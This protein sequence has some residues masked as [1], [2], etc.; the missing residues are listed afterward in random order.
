MVSRRQVLAGLSAVAVSGF[1]PVSRTWVSTARAA[2]TLDHIP[3][4]DGTLLTDPASLAPYATDAG[5][6][7]HETPV[8]VLRP[9]S[10]EDV[11]KMIRYCRRHRIQVAA[12]GQGHTTFGQSQ[13]AGLVVDMGSLNKIHSIK[14]TS[15]DIDAG[16]TWRALVDTSVPMGLTPPVLTGYIKLSIGG[17]L[18]VGGVSSTN[19]QGCQVDRVQELEVVTGEGEI[20]RCSEHEN[21][22]LFE[23]VLGGLGQCGIVTRAVV[24]MV[25]APLNARTFI[26]NY[27]DNATFF[28]DM[29]EILRRNEVEDVFCLFLPDASGHLVYGLNITKFYGTGA[30]PDGAHLLRGLSQPASAATVTDQPYLNYV[31]R[32]DVIIDF[33]QS[34]GL[35]DGVLHPWY[36]AWLPLETVERYVGDVIPTLAPEDVG[37]TGFVLLF[38]QKRSKLTRRFL[39]VPDHTEWV[40]LFDILTAAAAPGP[41]AAFQAKM[42]AR[43]GKLFDKARRAGGTRYPIGTIAFDRRDWKQQYGSDWDDFRRLKQHFDPDGILTPGPG[44]FG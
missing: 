22:D 35:F 27:T 19:R 5:S 6:A 12:R 30:A 33:F 29:N 21:R 16:L 34:I 42:L 2:G 24:D 38:P 20:R 7:I 23:A 8:A 17:T 1:N 36:D 3:P 15:A 37:P 26:L 25:P 4:L 28:R 31:E 39:K 18:A 40:F 11:A 44:I 14:P 10:T 13:V 43:N 32:T 9:G 41:D